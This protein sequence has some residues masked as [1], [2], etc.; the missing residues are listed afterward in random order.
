LALWA[1]LV[2]FLIYFAVFVAPKIADGQ[3]AAE[4]VRLQEIAAENE[5]YC[6]KWRMGPGTAMHDDCIYDL[7]ELRTK[8]E[9]RFAEDA[10]W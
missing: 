7:R 2:T 8:I 9:N 10:M 5:G 4:R 1:A 3:A 6:A